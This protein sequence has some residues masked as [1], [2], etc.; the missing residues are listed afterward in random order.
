MGPQIIIVL[1]TFLDWYK[2]LAEKVLAE[3]VLAEKWILSEREKD[4]IR[5]L[6][7]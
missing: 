6:G 4:I 3:K 2:V 1:S 5:R 7:K